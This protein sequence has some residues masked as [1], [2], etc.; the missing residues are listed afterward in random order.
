MTH[1]VWTWLCPGCDAK[2]VDAHA[3]LDTCSFCGAEW[4]PFKAHRDEVYAR[5]RVLGIDADE[6]RAEGETLARLASARAALRRVE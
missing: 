3:G 1:A 2:H 6:T 5:L 4:D